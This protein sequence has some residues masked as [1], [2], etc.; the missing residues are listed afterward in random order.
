M[1][2]IVVE[3][4]AGHAV[5]GGLLRDITRIGDDTLGMCCKPTELQIAKRI[6]DLNPCTQF[7]NG[8]TRQSA[9]RGDDR[10]IASGLSH[11]LEHQGKI[12]RIS[13]Q[14]LTVQGEH[15]IRPLLKIGQ[16]SRTAEAVIVETERIH[17][18]V[19]HHIGLGILGLF[20]GGDA[21]TADTCRE[22]IVAKGID[23]EAID[24]LRH[25][26]IE[27]TGACHKVSQTDAALLCND[28]CRHR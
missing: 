4:D 12:L 22:E 19:T 10:C 5:E 25:V 15:D 11:R 1:L 18:N 23:D 8:F 16:G 20:S 14:G 2:G 13:Y 28:R 24:L 21:C 17:Q 27:R 9:Q 26:N 3:R 7:L 6:N